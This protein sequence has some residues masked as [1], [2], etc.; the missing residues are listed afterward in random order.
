MNAQ[1]AI[2]IVAIPIY[3]RVMRASVLSRPGA[4][5]RDR[6]AALG[7]SERG[8]LIRRILPNSLTPL[9]VAGTLGIGRRSSRSQR[10]RSSGLGA[11]PRSPSGAR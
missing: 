11:E 9:I 4:R 10:S 5:L 6:V 3:A 8:M 7:E 1:F 2:A